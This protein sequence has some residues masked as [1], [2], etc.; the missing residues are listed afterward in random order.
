[1]ITRLLTALAIV[2]AVLALAGAPAQADP[3]PGNG[4][5]APGQHANS[6]QLPEPGWKPPACEKDRGS[7]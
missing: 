1:M 7:D 2:G 5:C 3:G 6:G 4:P